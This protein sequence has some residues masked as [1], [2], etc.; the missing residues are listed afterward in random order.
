M[1]VELFNTEKSYVESLQTIVLKY[2]NQLKSPEN[3]G[4]VDTQTVDEIFFMVPAILN[5][6]LNIVCFFHVFDDL[7]SQSRSL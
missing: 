3:A 6:M 2:L 1:V 7:C 4:L 5:I